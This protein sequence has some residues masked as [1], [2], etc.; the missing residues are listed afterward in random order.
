MKEI[1]AA[2]GETIRMASTYVS[3]GYLANQ[4]ILMGLEYAREDWRGARRTP[5]TPQETGA[6][7]GKGMRMMHMCMQACM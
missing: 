3:Q 7:G 1:V 2:F 4:A 5:V 6:R